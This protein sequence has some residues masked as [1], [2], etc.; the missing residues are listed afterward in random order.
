M[1]NEEMVRIERDAMRLVLSC[2]G[3][4][5]GGQCN[6]GAGQILMQSLIA[7]RPEVGTEAGMC[8]NLVD[9]GNLIPALHRMMIRMLAAGKGERTTEIGNG[10]VALLED[11]VKEIRQWLAA[12]EEATDDRRTD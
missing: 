8:L 5:A 1:P 6:E 11:R 4:V 10:V 2:C 7:G 12:Q 3:G 9:I